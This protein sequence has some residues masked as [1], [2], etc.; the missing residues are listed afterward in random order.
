M[1]AD[2]WEQVS[3]QIGFDRYSF[4]LVLSQSGEAW[5]TVQ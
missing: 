3:A 5:K 4:Q 1:S 2:Q